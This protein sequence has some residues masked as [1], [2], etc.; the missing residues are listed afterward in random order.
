ML[1]VMHLFV[2]LTCQLYIY[3]K[4]PFPLSLHSFLTYYLKKRNSW[5]RKQEGIQ[6][7]HYVFYYGSR[8]KEICVYGCYGIEDMKA[9]EKRCG[10][11]RDMEGKARYTSG[12]SLLRW[13]EWTFV[14]RQIF[15]TKNFSF[16]LARLNICLSHY[17]VYYDSN[18]TTYD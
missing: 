12:V 9:M 5:Y 4:A 10:D 13:H 8:R 6:V 14:Q 1:P 2:F 17:T 11:A 18:D 7:G 3:E 15:F 16:Q